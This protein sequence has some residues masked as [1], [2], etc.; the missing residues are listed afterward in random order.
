MVEILF[1]DNFQ[2]TYSKLKDQSIKTKIKKQI[3]KI[4]D[5]PEVGKPMRYERKGTREVYVNPFRIAYVYLPDEN[6]VIFLDLY[7]KDYQ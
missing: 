6:K 7:H 4:T 1:E 5:N 3:Q 2:K